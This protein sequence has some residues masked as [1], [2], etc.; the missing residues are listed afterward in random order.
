MGEGVSSPGVCYTVDSWDA[1]SLAAR[2]TMKAL[3]QPRDI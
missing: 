2:Q 3:K 1:S